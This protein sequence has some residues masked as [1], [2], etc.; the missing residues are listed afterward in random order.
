MNKGSSYYHCGGLEPLMG[1]TIPAHFAAVARRYAAREAIVSRHQK[2]RLTYSQ[3]QVESDRLAKGLLGMGFKRGERVGVWATNSIE[4][5]LLQLAMAR[6][7]VALVAINPGYRQQE[8]AYALQHSE[9]H[10]LFFMP[11]FR[12]SDYVS[13]LAEIVPSLK[14]SSPLL[15]HAEFPN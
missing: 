11:A 9:V 13:M 1:E 5:L 14:E 6:I 3:L 4:W 2:K 12:S 7:G 8:I 15:R 10:G